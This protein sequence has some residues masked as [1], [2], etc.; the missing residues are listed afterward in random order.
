MP[1]ASNLYQLSVQIVS[2]SSRRKWR[3]ACSISDVLRDPADQV[4]LHAR[5]VAVPHRAVIELVQ[6]EVRLQL[7][8]QSLQQVL[9]ERAGQAQRVVVGEQQIAFRLD[10]IRAQQQAIAGAKRR[11]YQA[12]ERGCAGPVEVADVR[13]QEDD[14]RRGCVRAP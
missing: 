2:P 7:R 11:P 3:A 8:V 6:R 9:V 5:R 13:S 12:E 10:E 4:H 1:S 14:E